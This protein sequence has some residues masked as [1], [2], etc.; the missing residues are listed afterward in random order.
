[1]FKTTEKA[2]P[3]GGRVEKGG[4]TMQQKPS[5]GNEVMEIEAEMRKAIEGRVFVKKSRLAKILDISP[6]SL[7]D[8]LIMENIPFYRHGRDSRIR[9]SDA[10][11]LM[12][13]GKTF[14]PR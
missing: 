11:R 13:A 1:M 14:S 12:Q 6:N 2:A 9:V 10:A 8:L 5:H 3:K 4:T 7:N